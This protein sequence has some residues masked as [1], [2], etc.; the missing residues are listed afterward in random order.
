MI[1]KKNIVFGFVY[2][3]LT[4]SLGPVMILKHF[5]ERRATEAVKIE[6]VG[7]LQQIVQDEYAVDLEPIK[8][9]DLAKANTE[10]ILAISART[11]AQNPINSIRSGPHAHGTLDAMLNIA[12]GVLLIFLAVP[13][14]LKQTISWL[15][16]VNTLTY[17]G[18]LY[19][20]I[21]LEQR[22]AA[23]LVN[24]WPFALSTGLTLC[25]I[26]LAGIAAAIGLRTT[27]VTD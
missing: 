22:W 10:A 21:G 6:K 2:L 14:W 20:V 23:P 4:V 11:N 3:P 5:D 19:L 12:V 18:M 26:L 25:S 27:P 17:S 8:P 9:L 1:G 7:V 16:I 15:F 24:G 13:R